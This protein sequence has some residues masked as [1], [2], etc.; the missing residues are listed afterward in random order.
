MNVGRED[1]LLWAL[2]AVPCAGAAACLLMRSQVQV[3]RLLLVVVAG[4]SGLAVYTSHLVFAGG[5][6]LG[7]GGLFSLDALSAYH[8]L[9]MTLVFFLS[10]VFAGP[11]FRAPIADGHFDA[12]SAR[13]FGAMWFL[14]L[15]AMVL[16]LTSNHL[17]LM[18]VGI[19]STTLMTT[20]LI[21]LHRSRESLEAT[22]KYLLIC[23][24]GIAISFM[25]TLLVGAATG[26][27]AGVEDPMLWTVLRTQAPH[28]EP[29]TMKMAFIFLLVGF[30]TKAGLAPMHSWLPDA[31]SQAP[32]P[33]SAVFSGI[34]LNTAL[35]CIL[36][37]VPIAEAATGNTGWSLGVLSVLGIL[38]MLIA[39]PFILFQRDAKRLLA[40][41][42]IEH[43]G[44][45]AVGVGLGGLGTVAAM[46]HTLNHSVCKSVGFFS[47]GRLGQMYGSHDMDRLKGTLKTSPL[48]G[49]GLLLSLLA[50]IGV[51]P[52]AV[53][54]SELQIVK[55]AMDS[56]STA[57]LVLFLLGAGVV[58]IAMIMHATSMA[59]GPAPEGAVAQKTGAVELV[60][61]AAPL[62]AA[63]ALG[64]FMPD[65][66]REMFVQAAAVVSPAR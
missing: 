26:R 25:G 27:L 9:V 36:R 4:F 64:V 7:A 34:M 38:S 19:E 17:G 33:V 18:W 53:F 60:L 14:S 63:A 15:A 2:L 28:L 37:Y 32:A 31:H 48:W 39:A 1:I 6:L 49:S 41:C 57:L 3:L 16:V 43:I 59:W 13:K 46:F 61:V 45:I 65:W 62:L 55:A 8:L 23:S 54:M 42:S 66:L 35:Y 10:T 47:A 30:G 11:Y 52:F 40:Y 22:W 24:V 20:F 29:T 21:C 12:V 51:V 50:L 58:F 44:I 56:R 5:P